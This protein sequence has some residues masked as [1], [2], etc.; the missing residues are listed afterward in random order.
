MAGLIL[1]Y[2]RT[3]ALWEEFADVRRW[4]VSDRGNLVRVWEGHTLTV[5]RCPRSPDRFGW[6]IG[7]GDERRFSQVTY[8]SEDD[9]LCALGDVLAFG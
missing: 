9:A 5:Y 7:H 8:A 4:R 3:Q 2:S 6:C 1:P